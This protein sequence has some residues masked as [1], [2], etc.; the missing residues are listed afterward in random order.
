MLQCAK[1]FLL[2]DLT[3][4]EPLAQYDPSLLWIIPPL[5]GEDIT[6]IYLL[7]TLIQPQAVIK[8]AKMK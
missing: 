8:K 4:E 6:K 2:V 3:R 5:L 7:A 1:L